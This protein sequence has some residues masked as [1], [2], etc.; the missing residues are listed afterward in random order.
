MITLPYRRHAPSHQH[1][2]EVPMALG[3]LARQRTDDEHQ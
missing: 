3:K 2:D 1:L